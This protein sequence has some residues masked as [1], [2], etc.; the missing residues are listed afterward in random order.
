[1]LERSE[2]PL[3]KDIRSLPHARPPEKTI[4]LVAAWVVVRRHR[5]LFAL[6]FAPVVLAGVAYAML[7]SPLYTAT[8]V[9][10]IDTRSRNPGQQSAAAS[11]AIESANVDSQVEVLR[12]EGVIRSV[13]EALDLTGDPEFMRRSSGPWQWLRLHV[14]DWFGLDLD[15]ARIDPAIFAIGVLEKNIVIK[16]LGLSYVI[17]LDYKSMSAKRAAQIANKIVERYIA[18]QVE[19]R[20]TAEKSFN[21]WL[22][23]RTVALRGEAVRTERMLADWKLAEATDRA[24]RAYGSGGEAAAIR[25]APL[26]QSLGRAAAEM[27][28]VARE[29]AELKEFES[30][31]QT[32]R[33]LAETFARRLAEFVPQGAGSLSE[34]RVISNALPPR[35]KSEP[36]SILVIGAAIALGGLGGLGAAA[37]REKTLRGIRSAAQLEAETGLHCVGTLARIPGTSRR[38]GRSDMPSP[39]DAALLRLVLARPGSSFAETVRTVRAGIRTPTIA[40]PAQTVGVVSTLAGEGRSVVSANLGHLCAASGTRTLL[41]DLDLRQAAL[42]R[43]LAPDATAG[44]ADVIAGTKSVSDVIRHD[45]ESG[46][47]IL[48]A[49]A[50]PPTDAFG[51]LSSAA[52]A[53]FLTIIAQQFDLVILHLPAILS[54]A[55]ARALAPA[56]DAY[57]L[58][59]AWGATEPA[60]LL[61]GM[62]TMPDI[63]ERLLGV[64]LN[65]APADA[66][67]DETASWGARPLGGAAPT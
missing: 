11:A 34:A 5:I 7:A 10:L 63:R 39:A 2:I 20:L 1:M 16:R 45:A 15:G 33:A 13:V 46:L 49:V 62:R 12:S 66:P 55:D 43:R 47:H 31:A 65:G 60:D 48:P 52:T 64:V 24:T 67:R 17:Q 29:N 57:V 35:E 9:L 25:E 6:I 54:S 27:A 41:I 42:S 38:R 36:K 23:R 53:Q 56:V 40:P 26:Q 4:S 8:S 28:E 59:V 32:S 14:M 3:R 18:D 44:V 21:D 51:V 30:A 22:E 50:L 37:L 61:Q 58:V 19:A